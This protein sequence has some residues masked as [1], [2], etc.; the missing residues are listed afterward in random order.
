MT[1]ASIW[2]SCVEMALLL[3]LAATPLFRAA[4]TPPSPQP[5]RI[6]TLDGLR[7]FL[8]LG[9]FFHHATIYHQ[10]L[11]SGDWG[12][13]PSRFYTGLGKIGVGFF[14]MITGYLF[15]TRLIREKGRPAWLKLYV[16]RIFRIAPLYLFAFF[17]MAITAFALTSF[18]LHVGP[19][20]LINELGRAFTFGI[21]QPININS[22]PHTD[23]LLDAVTWTLRDEWC[24]YL[25]LPFMAILA[26]RSGWHLPAVSTLLILGM[27]GKLFFPVKSHSHVIDLFLWGMLSASLL[28]H[29][30]MPKISDRIKSCLVVLLLFGIFLGRDA[31]NFQAV[32]CMGI[33]FYL[34]SGGCTIFG[35]LTTKPARRLGDIS[36]GIY[37]LQGLPQALFF[38]PRFFSAIELGSPAGH[39]LL[40]FVAAVFLISLATLTHVYIERPGIV[41]GKL[42]AQKLARRTPDI[43][44]PAPQN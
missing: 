4:D 16:G 5:Q 43:A 2:P 34:I 24:F 3:L 41:L 32:L 10:L 12:D 6:K 42:V 15:W 21:L 8:A 19:L 18:H 13:P 29:K 39:W 9:V 7:G 40:T 22:F 17:C 27:A 30:L 25:S 36:Y 20:A 38:R 26:R 31:T 1:Y 11:L 28:S 14:F 23:L 35:L 33:T 44:V 37:L